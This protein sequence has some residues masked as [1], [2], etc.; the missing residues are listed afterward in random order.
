MV[1]DLEGKAFEL[2][3]CDKHNP[4]KVEI[5]ADA[6]NTAIQ[7]DPYTEEVFRLRKKQEELRKKLKGKND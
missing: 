2:V 1:Y 7:F 3:I 5:E 6:K 4:G